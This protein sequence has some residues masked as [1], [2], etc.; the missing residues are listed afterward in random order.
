[1]VLVMGGVAILI[2]DTHS[3]LNTNPESVLFQE[4]FDTGLL[5]TDVWMLTHEGDVKMR[6]TDIFDTDASE[7]EDYRLRLGIDT[8]GTRDDTIK[9]VG[10]RSESAI[11]ISEGTHDISFELDWNNQS[12]GC[13]LTASFYLC[14]TATDGNPEEEDEWLKFEYIGV[15]PGYNARSLIASKVNGRI[16]YLSTDGWP[17]QKTGRSIGNQRIEIVIDDG[18][19]RVLENGTELFKSEDKV[20]EYPLTFIYFQMS[21]HSNY[22]LRE[23]YFDNVV[24][25]SV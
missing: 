2:R 23:I 16:E 19:I 4:D 13:Y 18:R 7:G 9:F 25:Q 1:M 10:V 6:I 21:S 20:I 15:P 22:P 11:N 17:K 24:V 8:I 5:D 14:P 12:N 3:F